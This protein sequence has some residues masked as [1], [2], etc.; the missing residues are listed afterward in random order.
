MK[1]L[2]FLL[3]I[4]FAF[5]Q[6]V[7]AADEETLLGGDF[8][9]GGFGGPVVKVSQVNNETAVLMGGRG[10]WI[11]NHSLI[12]GGGGYGLV[13]EI[14][15]PGVFINGRQANLQFGYGGFEIEYVAHPMEL[16]N[17][18]VYLLIGGGSV[19]N[20]IWDND[21]DDDEYDDY[22]SHQDNIYV[23]EPAVNVTL[24]VTSFFRVSGGV[25]YRY[26]TGVDIA[27]TSNEELTQPSYN[28]T[29]RFGK[30]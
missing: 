26:V 5:M 14:E 7:F 22:D 15:A 29:F 24:N 19:E 18:S 17:Y 28:L 20:T 11:I 30:F 27:G 6:T 13:N 8:T 9:S 2:A 4:A 3:I 1:K 10:G 16:L 12:L 23:V 21:Y 25:S